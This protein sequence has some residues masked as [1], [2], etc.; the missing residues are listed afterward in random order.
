MRALVRV[1]DLASSGKPDTLM[2]FYV[3]DSL[4]QILDAQ[5]LGR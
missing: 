1:D 3:G 5:R 4:L 2:F